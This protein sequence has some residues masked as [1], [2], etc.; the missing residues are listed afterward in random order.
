MKRPV[1]ITIAVIISIVILAQSGIFESLM[2]LLL[3][4][5][6]P[7]TSYSIPPNAMLLAVI[8]GTWLIVFKLAFS[9]IATLRT[10]KKAVK[11]RVERKKR[12]PVQ[13][14]SEI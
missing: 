1:L 3:V 8:A 12:M 14:F 6:V 7:G 5:A 4:G 9:E 13:R 10:Q 11:K 2:L